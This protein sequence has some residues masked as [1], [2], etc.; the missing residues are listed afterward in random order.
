MREL[1]GVGVRAEVVR[2]LLSVDAPQVNA[3]MVT[4][5]AGFAKRNVHDVLAS[6]HAAGAVRRWT[7]GNEQRYEV[8]R[9][10]WA[11]L[12]SLA[13]ER[14]PGEQPWPQ[15]LRGL[16][17]LLR[18]LQRVDIGQLSEYLLA[19]QS[20]DLLEVVRRDFEY[21]GIHVGSAPAAGAWDDLETLVGDALARLDIARES[22]RG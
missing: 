13:P 14:L 3:Q 21:A 18:W 22:A 5:S 17:T 19:S 12:L 9:G 8:D 15:L 1:L 10:A 6:L 4:R 20:R 11:D 16:R 2:F 7:V